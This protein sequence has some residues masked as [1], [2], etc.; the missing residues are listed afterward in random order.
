MIARDETRK[1]VTPSICRRHSL[2]EY[3]GQNR[4]RGPRACPTL[5]RAK[6]LSIL[7]LLMLPM[8]KGL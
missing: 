5:L 8:R 4:G 7:F 1:R 6:S 3:A 2:L